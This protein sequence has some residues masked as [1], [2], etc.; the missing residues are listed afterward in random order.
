MYGQTSSSDKIGTGESQGGVISKSWSQKGVKSERPIEPSYC[1]HREKFT[2]EDCGSTCNLPDT[3]IP[4][5][6]R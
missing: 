1:W 2:K 6:Y 4:G 3:D 5:Q